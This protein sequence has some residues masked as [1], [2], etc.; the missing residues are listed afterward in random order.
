MSLALVAGLT[1]LCAIAVR[2]PLPAP[3]LVPLTLVASLSLPALAGPRRRLLVVVLWLCAAL[4]LAA[5][6]R[7]V[8]HEAASGIV[9]GGTRTVANSAVS[10]LRELLSL[11]DGLRQGAQIDPDR[12]GIGS[13]AT[14][15]EL[16]GQQPWRAPHAPTSP[17]LERRMVERPALGGPAYQSAGYLFRLCLPTTT[18]TWTLVASPTVDEERAERRWLGYAWSAANTA[19]PPEAFAIDEHEGLYQWQGPP[20]AFL[21]TLHPVPCDS[22]QSHQ[23]VGGWQP[24]RGKRP[25]PKLPG[26]VASAGP[27]GVGG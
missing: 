22:L 21:G 14:L 4:T 20:E 15:G 9:E 8:L 13:A 12:D 2:W 17:I 25:R 19:G 7:F 18:G 27:P 1:L 10:Q 5:S 3:F 23:G 26:D 11:E 24:W 6:V 16:L